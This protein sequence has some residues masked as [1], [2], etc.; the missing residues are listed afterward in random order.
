M[1]RQVTV[2]TSL[3]S[4]VLSACE[5]DG[6]R[7]VVPP[8]AESQAAAQ[9]FM[10]RYPDAQV[11]FSPRRGKIL[12]IASLSPPFPYQATSGAPEALFAT[13]QTFFQDEAALFGIENPAEEL[14]IAA[15]GY[16]WR[17]SPARRGAL[18]S[19]R[20]EQIGPNGARIRENYG[21]A[22]FDAQFR[23]VAVFTQTQTSEEVR[24]AARRA[25]DE[26]AMAA[27]IESPLISPLPHQPPLSHQ[28]R[29]LPATISW[30]RI[31]YRMTLGQELIRKNGI[32]TERLLLDANGNV[33]QRR[34]D[35]P[36]EVV[37]APA[38][39]MTQT[40]TVS[41]TAPDFHGNRIEMPHGLALNAENLDQSY[42]ITAFQIPEVTRDFNYVAISDSAALPDRSFV[43]T[44]PITST[45]QSWVE[46]PG[47]I[48]LSDATILARNL[49]ATL[50]FYH[51]RFGIRSWDDQGSSF[52]AGI[53]GR[54]RRS[55]TRPDTNAYGA[56]GQMLIGDGRTLTGKAVSEA[57][58]VVGHEFTH[59]FISAFPDFFYEREAGAL[60]ESLCDFIGMT[61]AGHPTTQIGIA[62]GWPLRDLDEPAYFGQPEVYGDY[63]DL[64]LDDDNGG[65]HLNSGIMNRAL[66]RAAKGASQENME[67]AIPLSQLLLDGLRD[68]AW[69]PQSLLEDF[70][71]GMLLYCQMRDQ[72][73]RLPADSDSSL[74][75]SLETAFREGE[76]L[77]PAR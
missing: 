59:S 62:A 2:F 6:A 25:Q 17:G 50:R 1:K 13:A 16:E 65:V 30:I 49:E 70:S 10:S 38:S 21:V 53:R 71:V 68:I 76:L 54:S 42:L 72:A 37:P 28:L 58:D 12:A 66:Y 75:R 20:F 19:I 32:Y 22:L 56:N 61:V 8:L 44:R 47:Y 41:S 26:R 35:L 40:L 39:W 14:R 3:L 34:V 33:I 48:E 51:S 15:N 7:Y 5:G 74:C 31:G 43:S 23:L 9:E 27:A 69:S 36:S 29:E 46:E 67:G 11:F 60:N 77:S 18:S 57:L 63:D 24:E 64:P 73:A 55:P 52:F 45:A 4:L